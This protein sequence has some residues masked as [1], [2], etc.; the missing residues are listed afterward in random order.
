MLGR[1]LSIELTTRKMVSRGKYARRWLLTFIGALSV[2][3]LSQANAASPSG[4]FESRLSHLQRPGAC[5]ELPLF[6]VSTHR[7]RNS[8]DVN[9]GL[10]GNLRAQVVRIQIPWIDVEIN[11]KFDFEKFDY[12]VQGF[13]QKKKTILLVLAYG[14][15]DHT[16]GSWKAGF[17]FVPSTFE[18]REAYFTYLQAVV[19]HFHGPDI[20]YQIWNEPNIKK[21]WTLTA[22]DFG[23]LLKGATEAIRKIDPTAMV[24]AA[25]IA[26]EKNRDDFVREMTK[27]LGTDQIGAFA[28]HPYRQDGPENSL[29]DIAK[30]E[31]ASGA[32]RQRRSIW[33]T[34]W[35]YS[36]TWLSRTYPLDNLRDR[37]AIMTARL[38]L[39]A[40]IAR[41][42]AVL[43]YDL[44]DDGP[45]AD[46]PES[47]FGLYDYEFHAKKSALTFQAMTNLMSNCDTYNFTFDPVQKIITATF[48]GSSRISRAIWTYDSRY[49]HKLCFSS[50]SSNMTRLFDLSG[51]ALPIEYCPS[52]SNIKLRLREDFGPLILTT[53]R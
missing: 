24:V 17:P 34:E 16:N 46:N 45:D 42:K 2:I 12:L 3:A 27:A 52:S 40:A 38:M 28:F 19:E 31:N 32:T 23:T 14:H 6:G 15:P 41:A 22:A 49:N 36:E 33:L 43:L 48:T 44:I 30:F 26:N 39:T 18:Q 25:G 8:D 37:Q 9:I 50:G 1:T 21:Y 51:T 29:L 47:T 10:V 35:G 4:E 13:R 7:G 20:A 53:D 11:G 5:S